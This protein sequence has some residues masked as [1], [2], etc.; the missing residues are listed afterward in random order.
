MAKIFIY[1]TLSADNCYAT[2]EV[3]PANQLSKIEK[4]ILIK[5]GTGVTNKHLITPRGVVTEVTEEEL[6]HLE[7]NTCFKMH[8]DNGYIVVERH[9]EAVEKVVKNMKEKD[10]GAQAVPEDFG[11]DSKDNKNSAKPLG[12]K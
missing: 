12:K 3:N 11:P 10:G 8:K 4:N 1:S 5:G 2:Y 7:D 6:K 9:E